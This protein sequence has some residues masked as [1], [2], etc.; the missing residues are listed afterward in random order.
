MGQLSDNNDPAITVA[1]QSDGATTIVRVTGEIDIDT[2]PTLRA[3]VTPFL[4]HPLPH[5]I[6]FD[7]SDVTFLDSTGIRVLAKCHER[8]T[9]LGGRL[10]ITNTS[11][12]AARVLSLTGMARVFGL[13]TPDAHRD[14]PQPDHARPAERHA[15]HL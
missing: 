13:D 15:A 11:S 7:L 8:L 12:T 3:A 10:I 1:V 2:S 6:I 14:A 9:L 4:E 5:T